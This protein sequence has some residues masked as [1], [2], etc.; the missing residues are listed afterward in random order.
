MEEKQCLLAGKSTCRP[1][2]ECVTC[3][4]SSKKHRKRIGQIHAGLNMTYRM[5]ELPGEPVEKKLLTL[6]VHK[7]R[8]DDKNE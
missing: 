4:W 2:V 1:S 6:L 3:G 5:V 8:Q 7:N